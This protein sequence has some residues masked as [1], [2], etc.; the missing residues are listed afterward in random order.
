[1]K[2]EIAHNLEVVIGDFL[3]N[4]EY[5]E[6]DLPYNVIEDLADWMDIST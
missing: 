6:H 4:E 3:D 5:F 1:M 2:E